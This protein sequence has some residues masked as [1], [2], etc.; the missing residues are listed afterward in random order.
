MK[1][2][3]F[4]LLTLT[5]LTLTTTGCSLIEKKGNTDSTENPSIKIT[6]SDDDSTIHVKFSDLKK[7]DP[8][9]QEK[10]QMYMGEE[11]ENL[12]ETEEDEYIFDKALVGTWVDAAEPD[13]GLTFVFFDKTTGEYQDNG[14]VHQFTYTSTG[15]VLS[16]YS[17]I[18]DEEG[19]EKEIVTRYY[20]SVVSRI[21]NM[22]NTETEENIVFNKK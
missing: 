21:L 11:N 3:L 19:N 10:G 13:T 2:R 9:Y 4:L 5:T 8:N 22:K 20:Y 6:D 1:K 16:I 17:T 15:E 14:G 7:E 18:T 12:S